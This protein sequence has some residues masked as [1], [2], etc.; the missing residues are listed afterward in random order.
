MGRQ[1]RYPRKRDIEAGL[2]KNALEFIRQI[3]HSLIQQ[4]SSAKSCVPASPQPGCKELGETEPDVDSPKSHG[5]AGRGRRG[6]YCSK[7]R[8]IDVLQ[9][10]PERR[11]WLQFAPAEQRVDAKCFCFEI[12]CMG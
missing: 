8:N 10:S 9:G 3:L 12:Y 1:G 11:M 7:W 6:W 4:T 5:W 2:L